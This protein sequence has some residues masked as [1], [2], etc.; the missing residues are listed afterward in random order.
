[1]ENNVTHQELKTEEGSHNKGNELTWRAIDLARFGTNQ[2]YTPRVHRLTLPDSD[3]EI[4]AFLLEDWH[5]CCQSVNS[6]YVR[7]ERP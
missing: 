2:T 5:P 1:M 6:T 7:L 4:T 3:S